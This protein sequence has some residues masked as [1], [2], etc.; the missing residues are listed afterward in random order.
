MLRYSSFRL[1]AFAAAFILVSCADSSIQDKKITDQLITALDEANTTINQAT[2]IQMKS[3]EEK[4]MD[5]FTKERAEFWFKIAEKV[6]A[7][8]DRVFK[9]INQADQKQSNEKLIIEVYKNMLIYKSE[10][11]QTNEDLAKTFESHFSFIRTLVST[12]ETDS[13][14]KEIPGPFVSSKKNILFLLTI[15]KSKIKILENKIVTFCSIKSSSSPD[16]FE[17]YNPI[18]TQNSHILSPGSPL[19]IRAGMGYFTTKVSPEITIN[20]KIIPLLDS[21][22][23]LY[24]IKVPE[25]E[26]LYHLPIFLKF[27]NIYTGKVEIIR[28]DIK[29]TVQ[30]KCD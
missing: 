4:S 11:L 20:N 13:S 23:A 26:G 12:I 15:L 17:V 24:T 9:I 14:N 21:G 19:E 3:L 2:G 16:W 6:A 25:K 7:S 1:A 28:K 8:T 27:I 30:K 29:Y 10:V 22:Y 18:I 5:Y